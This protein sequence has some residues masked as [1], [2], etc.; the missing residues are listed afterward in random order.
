MCRT[1]PDRSWQLS[2]GLKGRVRTFLPG[3]IGLIDQVMTFF[4]L[5]NRWGWKSCGHALVLEPQ[6]TAGS[7]VPR[8]APCM[9][10]DVK[11]WYLSSFD[12][13]ETVRVPCAHHRVSNSR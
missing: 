6:L 5:L 10:H 8:P 11:K 4:E 13:R 7:N 2:G 1:L 3:L 9:S 12:R